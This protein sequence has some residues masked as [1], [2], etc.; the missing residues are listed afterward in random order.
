LPSADTFYTDRKTLSAAQGR[1][2][3]RL[4]D[5]PLMLTMIEW[6]RSASKDGGSPGRIRTSD[7]TV[8]SRPLYR[9]SY[10]GVLS[11]ILLL[12]AYRGEI[13]RWRID[14]IALEY[15]YESMARIVGT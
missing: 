5:S 8:N 2:D 12:S 15:V 1:L 14:I 6:C 9:L 4:K 13:K 11:E 10:R 3:E 7:M